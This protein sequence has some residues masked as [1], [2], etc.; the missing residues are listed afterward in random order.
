MFYRHFSDWEL[1]SVDSILELL[2]ADTPRRDGFDRMRWQ[3]NTLILQQS[4]TISIKH[5][6]HP[7]IQTQF[8]KF[9]QSTHQ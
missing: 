4:T 8:T 3:L 2:Y 7:P 6:H 5:I 1:E 9:T